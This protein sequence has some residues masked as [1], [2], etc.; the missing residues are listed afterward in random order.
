M[1]QKSRSVPRSS[2]FVETLLG[3]LAVVDCGFESCTDTIVLWSSIFTDRHIYADIVGA[4]ERNFRILQVDPPGHGE[5]VGVEREFTMLECATA[6]LT[7]MDHFHCERAFV[8][9]TSWGGLVA[10]EVALLAPDRVRGIAMMN[11]PMRLDARRVGV[12]TRMIAWGARWFSG[13]RVYRN[14]IARNFFHEESLQRNATF[15]NTFHAML[16]RANPRRL[17]AAVR[18]VLLRGTPLMN[19]LTGIRVP[20]LVIAGAE[21]AMYPVADQAEAS[22]RLQFGQLE[23]VPGRHIS[24]VDASQEVAT[25]LTKFFH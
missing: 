25:A 7:V 17:A 24:V 18:S 19:R 6:L 16:S 5:S 12:G 23:I 2:V 1:N 8:A 11:T 22:L 13:L 20:A 9:G 21:D 14:G 15:A 10:A 4:L 3:P